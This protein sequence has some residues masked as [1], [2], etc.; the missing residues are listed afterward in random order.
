MSPMWPDEMVAGLSLASAVVCTEIEVST[1]CPAPMVSPLSVTVTTV[2]TA[3][4]EAV[5]VS[6]MAVAVGAAL[7][8][9][10][11]PLIAAVGA[12]NVAKKPIG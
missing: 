8:A 4:E 9:N 3:T 5:T 10:M 11:V 1:P 2:L 6:T 12:G 7:V